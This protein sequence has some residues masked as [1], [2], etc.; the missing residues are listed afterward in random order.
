MAKAK[1]KRKLKVYRTPIGFHD[2]I[3]A[4][5]SRKAALA[6]WGS[7]TDLFAR[8]SA[9]EVV[10][11][12]LTEAPLE[13][14]GTVFRRLRGSAKEQ[15]EALEPKSAKGSAKRERPRK[16][17]SR[18]KLTEAE[19]ALQALTKAQGNEAADLERRAKALEREKAALAKRQER[20]REAAE[21]KERL[22]REAY[23]AAMRDWSG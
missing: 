8:G 20:E 16:K 18:S 5:P 3:V 4:A 1:R 19:K 6:A 10:D 7:D 17:P 21:K 23:E 13:Q 22:A 12:E 11:P 9:E 2:A 14:P 15:M